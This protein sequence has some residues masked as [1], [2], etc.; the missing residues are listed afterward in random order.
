MALRLPS[1]SSSP[2]EVNASGEAHAK[3]PRPR[4][5]QVM[6]AMKIAR[7]ILRNLFTKGMA[8]D[9][10]RTLSLTNPKVAERLL[11]QAPVVGFLLQVGFE[12][13]GEALTFRG[14]IGS[15]LER[16]KKEFEGVSAL[17]AEAVHENAAGNANTSVATKRKIP[18]VFADT[19]K[20]SIKA[21]MREKE[22]MKRKAKQA[23]ERK[24]RK[25]LLK[26]FDRD[27]EARKQPGWQA[28]LSGAN[29]GAAPSAQASEGA[30]LHAY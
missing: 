17:L 26:G 13:T 25:E 28:K 1:S 18:S 30:N 2:P 16:L 10:Y 22:E 5:P 19:G 11:S 4:S 6:A 27:K 29:R 15:Q 9:K 3:L 21:Q 7:T 24:R 14:D 23:E 20:K 8:D 12:N